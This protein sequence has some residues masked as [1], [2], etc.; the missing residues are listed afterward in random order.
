MMK[1]FQH[2]KKRGKIRGR[3]NALV[4]SVVESVGF[5]VVIIDADNHQIVYANPMAMKLSQYSQ[6]DLLGRICHRIVCPAEVGKCPIT[7]LGH[8]VDNSERML[9]RADGTTLPIIKTV[10]PLELKGKRYLIETFI[11]YS[12]R[13]ELAEKLL[14]ISYH[15]TLTGL[16]NRRSFENQI[17]EVIAGD[18]RSIGVII[19]DAD[20]LKTVNDA[21]GHDAGDYMLK[22]IAHI[23][24]AATEDEDIIA[25]VGGDEF[26]IIIK[27]CNEEKISH[28]LQS[29]RTLLTEH[30]EHNK[31]EISLSIGY[32]YNQQGEDF[33]IHQLLKEADK[34]MY[35][36]KLLQRHSA[37]SAIVSTLTN[38]LTERDLVTGG[39]ADR[40]LDMAELMGKE[41]ALKDS[42]LV[43]LK[44]LAQ[45]H[46]IGKIA[47]PDAVL[48][49]PAALT[50]EEWEV[51]RSHCQI[52][53]RI[54]NAANVFIEI[55]ELILMHHEWWDGSGY[56][57]G[58]KGESI[59]LECRILAIIDAYDAMTSDRP[60]R[61]AMSKEAAINELRTGAGTQFDPNLVDVFIQMIE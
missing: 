45:F 9:I 30:N 2:K 20:G 4:N 15:D 23:L 37:K 25:R 55:S 57:L 35:Q 3:M 59:P 13:K 26:A 31:I 7:D 28:I 60:Y 47:I 10:V 8:E 54:A 51:M 56:P 5:A 34:N 48:G 29:I 39:H 24:T 49:K 21:V 36:E 14:Y 50:E 32:A 19:C 17:A 42:N 38:L 52:G 53:F 44:L 22:E 12:E 27:N 33:T 46:D 6:L 43:S 18:E 11:D 41:M 61:K 58:V 16:H 1:L 40:M